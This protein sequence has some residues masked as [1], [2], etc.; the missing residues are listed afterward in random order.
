M[1]ATPGPERVF[2]AEEQDPR[3]YRCLSTAPSLLNYP[4]LPDALNSHLLD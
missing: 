1:M 3:C 4:I 2:T